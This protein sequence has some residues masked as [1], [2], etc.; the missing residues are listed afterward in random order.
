MGKGCSFSCDVFPLCLLP[1]PHLDKKDLCHHHLPLFTIL[2]H[3]AGSRE[4]GRWREGWVGGRG[5][6]TPRKEREA[7]GFQAS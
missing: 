5:L 2:E 4:M 7:A 3:W 6:G 1:G